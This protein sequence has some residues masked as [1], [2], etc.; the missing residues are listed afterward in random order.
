MKK[1]LL[2]ILIILFFNSCAQ[3]K[4]PSFTSGSKSDAI[5]TVTYEY[6]NSVNP[7]KWN[8]SGYDEK[9]VEK[10][11]N[12]GFV[13]AVKFDRGKRSCLA[14]NGWGWCVYWQE[15]LNYQC[16]DELIKHSK[17]TEENRELIES[18]QSVKENDCIDCPWPN[19]NSTCI[20]VLGP[21][22]ECT[23]LGSNRCCTPIQP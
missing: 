11:Q 22:Y 9:A 14:I 1:F 12:W 8:W 19:G 23:G 7:N 18:R 16:T 2:T 21:D 15:N 20:E 4:Y 6:S 17:I 3:S 5:V 10:C 13:D